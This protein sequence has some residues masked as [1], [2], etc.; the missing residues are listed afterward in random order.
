MKSKDGVC[1][2]LTVIIHH[3]EAQTGRSVKY[4][5]TDDGGEF[6]SLKPYLRSKGITHEKSAPYAQDQDGVAERSIRTILKRAR[7]MLIH[8]NLPHR[9]WPEAISAACYITNRLPTKAL[10]GMTPYK[11][12]HGH[13]PDL[14]NLRVYG[15]DAYVMDYNS[16]AKGKMYPRSW[17]E[18]LVGYEAKNQ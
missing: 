4:L 11:A 16:K 6:K 1:D 2:E 18:T 15:C 8:A 9:L 7:T 12:W 5:R 3:I 14:S 10:D 13:K 17:L